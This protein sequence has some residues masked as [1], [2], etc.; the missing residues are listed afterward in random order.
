V[1][2]QKQLIDFLHVH[3]RGK[4]DAERVL[5]VHQITSPIA[6]QMDGDVEIKNLLVKIE[7]ARQYHR[8]F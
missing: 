4:P 6:E 2:M 3:D 8:I 7:E 5:Y 1:T